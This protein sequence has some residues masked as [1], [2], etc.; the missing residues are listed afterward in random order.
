[1]TQ[2]NTPYKGS[3]LKKIL[4][5][6]AIGFG[7][8]TLLSA[9][10]PFKFGIMIMG[11]GLI[12]PGAWFF[13]H[14]RKV[15]AGTPMKRHWGIVGVTSAAMV[16]GG[17]GNAEPP[18]E[19]N[20]TPAAIVSTT[21]NT[22]PTS[23]TSAVTTSKTTTSKPTTT[24]KAEPSTTVTKTATVVET[25]TATVVETVVVTQPAPKP[26]E[27]NRQPQGFVAPPPAQTPTPT[28][29]QSSAYYS[30]CAEAK[31]AGAAPLYQGAP[32]YRSG[33]DKDGDGV[34]CEK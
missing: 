6:T 4:A 27:P 14:E 21:T 24:R 34:A 32:G 23:T 20:K 33:L 18:E 2:Q 19:P 16:F 8:L 17:A 13:L 5:I 11:M 22:A 7:C 1:M 3:L 30:S 31:A 25:A 29:A 12:L 10:I 26:V 15:K 9:L 28:P